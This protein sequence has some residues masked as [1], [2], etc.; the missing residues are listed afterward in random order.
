MAP[1]AGHGTVTACYQGL[2]IF[3]A[4]DPVRDTQG[5]FMSKI[6][7]GL[8]CSLLAAVALG[9]TACS[10]GPDARWDSS[11]AV[12]SLDIYP[13]LE[14]TLFASEPEL[15]NPTNIDV[16][17]RGRVWACD[18]VNYREHGRNDKRPEGDRILILED[19]DA[20]GVADSSKVYYQGR[21]VDAALGIAV[22]GNKVIVTAAPNVI[23]FTDED[24]DDKPDRKEYLF[25]RSGAPQND[26]STHSLSFGPDGNF[27]WN[28]GNG[29]R[30]VHDKDGFLVID[31]A[32]H[33][34]LDRNYERALRENPEMPRP[35]FAN[36]LVGR[37][38]PYQGG[39]VFRS[40]PDGRRTDVLGHNF[41]NNYEV[42]VDSL[43]GLWQSDNDNDGSYACRLNYILEYGNYGYRDELTGAGNE[44]RRT[45]RS[46]VVPHRHW[47]QN[48][49]GVVPNLLVTGAGS[50]TGVTVYEGRLLPSEFWD[51]VLATDAGPGV[52]RG[53][54]SEKEGAGYKA[55]MVDLLK[56]ERDKWVRPVDVAVA[57]DGSLFVSDW[58]DPVIGWNRQQD[59][60]RGRI[61]RIAP[62]ESEYRAPPH[63]FDTSE[64]AV[65]ALK[66]PNPSTRYL[67]WQAL[68]AGGE[69]AEAALARLF[70]EGGET[71]LRARALWLL[72]RIKGSGGTYLEEAFRDEEEDIRIV[73][74]RAARQLEQDLVPI[75]ESLASDPSPHV[76]RECAI[77]LR[78]VSAADASA[79]WARLASRHEAGDRWYLESLGIA[80]DGRWDSFLEAWL[81]TAG[82]NWNTPAGRDILWRSRA[83]S[84]PSYLARIL[85]APGIA[86]DEAARYLRAFDFQP[87][88]GAKARNLRQLALGRSSDGASRAFFVA[89]EALLRLPKLN[90]ASRSG[91]RESLE[92]LLERGEGTEQFALLVQRYE[93]RSRYPSLVGVAARN[94]DNPIGIASVRTL[95]E[96]GAADAILGFIREG[97][98]LAPAVV[99]AVGNTRA[100]HAVPVLENL[101]ID[102]NLPPNVTDRAVRSLATFSQGVEALVEI[103]RR[104]DFPPDLAEVAG[105][106][107]T[108]SMHV[109][110]RD[111]AAKL[112]PV[113]P[114]KNSEPLPQMTE[115][116]VYVG[117]PGK[118][119]DVFERATCSDCH[120]VNG[121]G[122][123]FGPE[124]S[125]I[126][127]KLSKAGLYESIL[128]P[129]A[130]VSPSFELVHFALANQEEV[131]GFVLSDTAESLTLR[132]EGG[133]VAE[134]RKDEIVD[135]RESTVSA[136][137]DDLQ[138][139]MSV[140]DLVD[141]VEYLSRLR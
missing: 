76:R 127:N 116:L 62:T 53:I 16:D 30:Y 112:F 77:A 81:T 141:V 95:L 38:S 125:E 2:A 27:Y 5:V 98:E 140:D 111:E 58:Y 50:P 26:H 64:G 79:I 6:I 117:D 17:H 49:P 103:A 135:R 47:H 78:D 46:E 3:D 23:V 139:Q 66:S 119:A 124:L 122:T 33:P 113:P 43:G 40:G 110:L 48:D 75:L 52:L 22:L 84:T 18:V 86:D 136:M 129:S 32:G 97:S 85:S 118:G 90:L 108:R 19:T 37:S 63:D 120:I 7:Q 109:R 96:E 104:G 44:A 70:R 35:D 67:A 8:C 31:E 74:I 55:R 1:F 28:M 13:G 83:S 68:D 34:V 4:K 134:F 60:T 59:L 105:A 133:I 73:S 101:V 25:T 89:A 42:A 20:D 45:G 123:N 82:R 130:S 36:A 91:T 138:E 93:L 14:A 15:T 51:Q 71:R 12:G 102:R 41:R 61:F 132:M 80:A 99:E 9:G 54:V 94:K 137:P 126:G 121:E 107:I 92:E 128:D 24:G 87:E 21:D 57:P 10:Q 131:S 69:A 114:M 29:G 56:G 72:A 65:E 39:M 106:A 88:S 11:Q 115:L 100:T